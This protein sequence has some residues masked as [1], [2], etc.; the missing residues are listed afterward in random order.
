MSSPYRGSMLRVGLTGG[1]GSGKSTVARR[2][3][4]L[5]ALVIDADVV[6]REVVA[7][8]SPGLAAVVDRFGAQVVLED[9]S[10]NRSSLAA[11]V[12]GNA[13]ARR[14]LEQITHP[15]IRARTKEIIDG[16][17]LDQVVAYD[18]P[19]LVENRLGVG[20]HLVIVVTAKPAIRIA[21]L[22]ERRGMSEADVRARMDHQA[23]DDQRRAAGDILLENNGAVAEL[24][25]AVDQIWEH[26]LQPYDE[27]LRFGRRHR[28]TGV[29]QLVPYDE[30]WPATAERIIDR[31]CYVLGERAPEMEHIGSTSVPGLP[32]RDVIDLQLGVADLRDADDPDFV[33]TLTEL[34]FPRSQ[35]NSMDTP[36]DLLPDPSLW[37]KR[38]HGSSD[39]HRAVHLHV[40]E[41][42]SAGWQYA[43]LQRDWLRSD[44]AAR[45][46]YLAEKQRLIANVDS[47]D[48]YREQKEP[49][50]N[51][52]WPRMQAWAQR[53]GWQA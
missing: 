52:V 24:V 33:R 51:A 5:G 9:G 42:Q 13:E 12:F 37:I 1:I 47:G 21:R 20:Y 36:K 19:L 17:P 18:V 31:I 43:M 53:H 46:D 29:P 49:W 38:Y 7:P 34:G 4:E 10:L 40:R 22:A 39:P 44:G 27:N 14:A 2:L 25:A 8:G 23:T 15:L 35:G 30:R 45:E 6:A 11:H 26:R 50:F 32:A 28:R 16:A 41:L 3:R 48:A